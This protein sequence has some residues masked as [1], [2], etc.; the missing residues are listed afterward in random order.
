MRFSIR[1]LVWLTV[2][3][4]LAATIYAE[5]VT[6]KR[7]VA[8][9]NEL[10]EKQAQESAA[11]IA[12][13]RAKAAGLYQQNLILQHQLVVQIEKQRQREAEEAQ[14]QR[15]AAVLS[16]FSQP[17]PQSPVLIPD[18]AESESRSESAP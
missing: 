2:V 1:D 13:L 18:E 5:R 4:A 15:R 12:A 10:S 6:T 16:R 7:L 14:L 3:V 9:W 8:K 11:A 17:L